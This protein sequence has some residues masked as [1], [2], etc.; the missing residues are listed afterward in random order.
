[1]SEELG[2]N[3]SL[4]VYL[5]SLNVIIN[6]CDGFVKECDSSTQ[7]MLCMLLKSCTRDLTWVFLNWIFP[8]C[9]H[10]SSTSTKANS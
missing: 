2:L 4:Q 3:S 1:M 5:V 9:S 8:T 10:E 6:H 7:S